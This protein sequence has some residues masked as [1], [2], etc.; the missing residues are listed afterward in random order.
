M[1]VRGL[2][3]VCA[4]LVLCG[5]PLASARVQALPGDFSVEAT[6][7]TGA[8]PTWDETG[9]TCAP[10][11]GSPFSFGPTTV[12]CND[13]VN[14]TVSFT[15]TVVDTTPPAFSG[16]PADISTPAA[17]SSGAVVTYTDPTATDLVDGSRPV[18][19]SPGSGSTFPAGATTPV[20]CSASD[21]RSNSSSATFNVTV[22]PWDSTPPN[23]GVPADITAEATSSAG[24]AVS[25]SVSFS[26]PDDSVA[27]SGCDA[28]SG[29]TFALGQHTVTCN[30]TDSHAN[31][32]TATFK[33]TVVDTTGPV[34]SNV[35]GPI[36]Q[37]ATSTSG[38]VATY[39][40]PT[41]Q[42]AVTGPRPVGCSPSSGSTFPIGT[43]AVN[44]SAGDGNGNT[45]N[46]S[47]NV[48]VQDTTPPVINGSSVPS[49]ISADATSPSGAAVTYSTPS[50]TDLGASA[51]VSCSPASG[52]TFAV[53]TTTV[54]C[55]ANDGRGNTSTAQFHVN[56]APFDTTPP[57]I[58]VPADIVVEAVSLSGRSV[59]YS[60]TF[61]D[62]DDAVLSSGCSPVSGS[63][64]GLGTTTV[65]CTATDHHSNTSNKS[66]KVTVQDTTPPVISASTVPSDISADATSPSGAAVTY[67]TPS[68]TDLGASAPVNCLPASGSTFA[69]GT[70][71][72]TCTANDGRGNTSSAQFHVI[73]APFDATPPVIAVPADITVEAVNGSGK[74]VSYSVGFSDPDDAVL[75]SSCS[76]VSGSTFGLG[77]T[78]VNCTAT[79][80]HNN[81]ANKSFKVTVQ[82][83]TAPTVGA[84]PADITKEATGPGGVVVTFTK[85]SATDTVDGTVPVT[86][87]PASGATF[88]VGTTQ[89]NCTATD[90]HGNSATRSFFVTVQ[91]TSPPVFGSAPDV[92]AD[93]SPGGSTVVSYTKPSA[94]DAVEGVRPVTCSPASGASFPIGSTT[95]TCTS[96]DSTGHV[97][98]TTFRVIVSDRTPPVIT[99][100]A[101]ITAEATSTV[102]AAVTYT[103]GASDPDDAVSASSCTPASGATFALGVTT[104]TCNATDSHSNSASK[105]FKVTVV[106]TTP[107]TLSNVP[108]D[109]TVEANGPSGSKVNYTPPTAVD[110]GT[111]IVSVPCVP[112]SGS[113]F[114]LGAMTV[115]CSAADGH[116]NTGTA[117]FKVKV[118]DTTPPTLIPPGDTSVYATSEGGS[119]AADQGPITKFIF[120]YNVSDIADPSPKVTANS[121]AFFPVGTTTVIFT[122]VDASGNKASASA[123][124]TVLP[125]PAPGTTPPALPPPTDNKPPGQ[126][127]NLQAKGGDG[128]AILKWT[129][130]TDPDFDHTEIT[131]TAGLTPKGAGAGPGTVVYSGKGTTFTDRGLQNGVEYRYVIASV[132]KNGNKGAGVPAVVLPKKAFLRTPADGAKLKQIP[133]QFVWLADPKATYYNLQL[134]AGGTPLFKSTATPST[135]ILSTWTTGPLFVFKSPWKWEGRSYKMTKGVYTW[136]VWPGYGARE[137]VKYGPLLGTATFQVTPAKPKPKAKPKKKP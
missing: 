44:C 91:D 121:P 40:N 120:G 24:A 102:G 33:I 64:F 137:A 123:K 77:T 18:S 100:P 72:V 45:S 124:L 71:T 125:K 67:S 10:A 29:A 122:A 6:G 57:V 83:T 51:A 23:I 111:P 109:I 22:G 110:L 85:P 118:V 94:I 47:F 73:I 95:V 128:R 56:I 26:D 60:V 126:V 20:T 48:T 15:V 41:A 135:K 92:N 54:T 11:S 108:A 105:T 90:A 58:G 114:P 134:F 35:P 25:F 5:T 99:V 76:P 89:V 75:S 88:T 107:P 61:T 78:T 43:T 127:Q 131:R 9:Y 55:T 16:V 106:D 52:S 113:T 84:P 133:K 28:T 62:P 30:A 116:G 4:V 39:S 14:P 98:T 13:G 101:D 59:T 93:A 42:D 96:S 130:P 1:R 36:T 97:A 53:G 27:T 31:S 2:I 70:T 103:F 46:A 66:F 115:N 19:C 65:N 12:S 68:A 104:V 3:A 21:T 81:T 80:H 86:C 79:D 112:A 119:D 82:D 63:T 87:T 17:S 32:S 37:E 136:Y 34:I 69:V 49:D 129:N 50:A 132:D 38:A 74:S 117:T 7:P 8:A